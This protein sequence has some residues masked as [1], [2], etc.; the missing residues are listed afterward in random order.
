MAIVV[1]PG[2]IVGTEKRYPGPSRDCLELETCR[3]EPSFSSRHERNFQSLLGSKGFDH[4]G[5]MAGVLCVSDGECEVV[6]LVRKCSDDLGD[7]AFSAGDQFDCGQP[8]GNEEVLLVDELHRF[9]G[10][11]DPPGEW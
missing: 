1:K 11:D 2:V 10:L 4:H 6:E 7:G 3:H 5:A 9:Q 8:R